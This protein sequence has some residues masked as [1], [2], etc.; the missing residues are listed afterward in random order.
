M[1]NKS[2]KISPMIKMSEMCE[3]V[4]DNVVPDFDRRHKQSPAQHDAALSGATAPPC[5]NVPEI[6]AR[7]GEL[8]FLALAFYGSA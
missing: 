3:F 8:H 1:I 2:P 4:D 5:S 6:K 7:R